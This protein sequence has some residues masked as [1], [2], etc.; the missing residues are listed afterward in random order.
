M[1]VCFNKD[2]EKKKNVNIISIHVFDDRYSESSSDLNFNQT[3]NC[4]NWERW[5]MDSQEE[6]LYEITV[7]LCTISKNNVTRLAK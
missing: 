3:N 6:H 4:F 2:L 1:Y 5:I 7:Q